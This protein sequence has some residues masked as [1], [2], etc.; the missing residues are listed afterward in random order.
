MAKKSNSKPQKRSHK[1][2]SYKF[3]SIPFLSGFLVVIL[4]VAVLYLNLSAKT[5]KSDSTINPQAPQNSANK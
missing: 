2:A 3:L 1:K 5:V 4:L